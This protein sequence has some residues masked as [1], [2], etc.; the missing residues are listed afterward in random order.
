MLIHKFCSTVITVTWNARVGSTLWQSQ[1]PIISFVTQSHQH[2][3][4]SFLKDPIHS[5]SFHSFLCEIVIFTDVTNAVLVWNVFQGQNFPW[6]QV[7]EC[8]QGNRFKI[9]FHTV[10]PV[11]TVGIFNWWKQESLACMTD[12]WVSDADAICLPETHSMFFSFWKCL[13]FLLSR[14]T[15]A[16]LVKWFVWHMK[17]FGSCSEIPKFWFDWVNKSFVFSQSPLCFESLQLKKANSFPWLYCRQF[18]LQSLQFCWWC[19]C[20]LTYFSHK[21]CEMVIV[22]PYWSAYSLPALPVF[23]QILHFAINISIVIPVCTNSLSVQCFLTINL[24][25]W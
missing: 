2:F 13:L 24:V 17:T 21:S 19:W 16:Q 1:I 25:L 15:P 22:I 8:C 18:L 10:F 4:T 9:F 5:S 23:F 20:Y 7:V 11:Q 3:L 12:R 6:M 14:G